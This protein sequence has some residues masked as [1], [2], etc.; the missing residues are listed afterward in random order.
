MNLHP[1]MLAVLG[2]VALASACGGDSSGPSPLSAC[3]APAPQLSLVVAQYVSL[4]PVL[5]SGCVTFAANSSTDTAEY[6]VL[7][8]SAGGAPAFSA[9]FDLASGTASRSTTLP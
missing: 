8:Q 1:S 9:P 7:A 3:G 4:D 2:A 5:D 6:L